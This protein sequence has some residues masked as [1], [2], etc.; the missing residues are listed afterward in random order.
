MHVDDATPDHDEQLA[1][2]HARVRTRLVEH[3]TLAGLPTGEAF[4]ALTEL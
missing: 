2:F 1:A 4:K 3:G